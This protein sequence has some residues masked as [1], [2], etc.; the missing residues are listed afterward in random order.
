MQIDRRRET[1]R[2]I[3]R[4]W[5]DNIKIDL[6]EVGWDIMDSIHVAQNRDQGRA[7]VNMVM[8]FPFP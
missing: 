1:T 6:R 4:R 3:R 7:L 8:N 5:E 2:N